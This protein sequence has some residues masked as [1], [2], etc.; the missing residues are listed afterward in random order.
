[1]N[2]ETRTCRDC[3]MTKPLSQFSQY[4]NKNGLLIVFPLCLVCQRE[5]G[6]RHAARS[7][8]NSGTKRTPA[9]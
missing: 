7:S 2:E 6:R 9:A 1:M 4:T 3:R 5:M 8:G